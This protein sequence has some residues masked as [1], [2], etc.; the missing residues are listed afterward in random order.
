MSIVL[1]VLLPFRLC[2]SSVLY[3]EKEDGETIHKDTKNKI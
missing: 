2:Y 3:I 1:I